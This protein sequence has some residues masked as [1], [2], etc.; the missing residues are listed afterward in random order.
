MYGKVCLVAPL[1]YS[2]DDMVPDAKAPN[3]GFLCQVFK[4]P[5]LKRALG[6]ANA[7]GV[8]LIREPATLECPGFGDVGTL[9]LQHP[10]SGALIQLY[11]A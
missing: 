9:L 6:Q 4:V 5:S 7:L 1:N 3:L 10:G 8:S 11:E 2:C